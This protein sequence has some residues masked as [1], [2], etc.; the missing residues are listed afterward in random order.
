MPRHTSASALRTALLVLIVGLIATG[1]W[2]PTHVLAANPPAS[3]AADSGSA[4][5]SGTVTFPGGAPANLIL[6]TAYTT[7][8][9][10]G[11]YDYTDTSG[12]YQITGLI[13]GS[14][15]LKFEP[16]S[17]G[18]A[19]EWYNNQPSPLT[20]A[21]VTVPDGGSVTG[22]NVELALGARFS[23][24]VT[25][26][27]GGPIQYINV[28]VYDSAGQQVA[29]ASTDAAGNYITN[30]GLPSGSYRV[31]F[32]SGAGYLGSFYDGAATLEEA[33][34]LAVTAPAVRNDI[35]AALAPGGEIRG[36]VTDATTG[37]PI[38]S[39]SVS[40][41]GANGSASDYTD[42]AGNYVL[43]G[44]GSGSYTVRA[45]PT[46][47]G[48]L[49]GEERTASVSAP[50][51]TTGIDFA[52]SH[53]GAITGVVRGPGGTP[54]QNITIYISNED[55]SF[56]DYVNT[57]ASGV[58]LAEG[59]PSGEYTVFFRPNAHIPEVYDDNSQYQEADRI[60]V[61]A[62]ETVTGIDAQ[63]A[64]GAAVRGT[65][66]DATTGLPIEDIFVEIL[67]LDG[68]RID[69]DF[70]DSAGTYE[71][72]STLPSGSYL[73]RFNAEDRN[74]GC[75][76]VTAYY[77]G[78]LTL[79]E[80][81]PV[82][83]TAPN[84][85]TNI[86]A[87]LSRGSII[88]GR[89][90]DAE[91]GAPITSGSVVV[92]DSEGEFAMFGRI[93]FLGGYRTGTGLPSGSYTI[94]F[95]DGDGGYVDEFYDD[96][97]TLATA[98]PVVLNAPTDLTGIDAELVKGGLISG[99]ATDS[100][101]GGP[102]TDGYVIVYDTSGNEVG[103]GD[104]GS[105]GSYDVLDGLATGSYYVAVVPYSTEEEQVAG[106]MAA[107]S[108][109]PTLDSATYGQMTTFYGDSFGPGGATPVAVTAGA[110]T[111]SIDITVRRGVILPITG[112]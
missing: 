88:F 5:I 108:I 80:A 67:D 35:D 33:T 103:Y 76:Y 107:P 21:P 102:F 90:T 63:L 13:G 61:T 110:T 79:D 45:G 6:V 26:E 29:S 96:Q 95:R 43:T 46:F 100:A 104:I 7:Y 16:Y 73:V 72:P 18:Y 25:A 55:G 98:T 83:L 36:T 48:T 40:A 49:V 41:S 97:P 74:A 37:L 27:G 47:G 89:V 42:A 60:T 52:L 19:T 112:R 62:P 4:T 31:A 51:A 64:Q 86:D 65:V 56:Q 70:T 50:D 30:P 23:G 81:T 77:G 34:P 39:A 87:E 82:E 10:R 53:G 32:A 78:A 12:N 75:A 84:V 69:T 54:L 9:D 15:L 8:G 14:Y 58:Y 1:G 92:R 3:C 2:R 59:L 17:G 101:T 85:A 44:L 99:I 68:G 105:D 66:T 28:R 106:V 24:Q 91:T 111:P 11:G 20:T 38:A 94:E 93:S 109:G 71:I 57:N 22:V